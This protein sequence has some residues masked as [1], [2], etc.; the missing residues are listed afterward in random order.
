M[1]THPHHQQQQMMHYTGN[2]LSSASSAPP[3]GLVTS[4]L[5]TPHI[6]TRPPLMQHIMP[7]TT[8]MAQSNLY[9]D[10]GGFPDLFNV[11][12]TSEDSLLV[13]KLILTSNNSY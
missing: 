5:P 6:T 8:Q 3:S 1:G 7:P 10:Q 2:P 4:P 9:G 12:T 13:G 11:T